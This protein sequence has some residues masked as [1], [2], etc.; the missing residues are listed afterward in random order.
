MDFSLPARSK[1]LHDR[2]NLD[3]HFSELLA[4]L[5]HIAWFLLCR[6]PFPAAV[7]PE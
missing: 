3:G 2:L 6:G 4:N 5:I 1:T 7:L